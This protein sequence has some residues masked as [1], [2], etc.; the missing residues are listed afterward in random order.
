MLSANQQKPD[1]SR[2]VYFAYLLKLF[3]GLS[4]YLVLELVGM[5]EKKNVKTDSFP[6]LGVSKNVK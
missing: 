3:L 4:A 2:I 5:L 6:S 1:Y